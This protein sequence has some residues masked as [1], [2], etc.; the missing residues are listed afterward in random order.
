MSD[1]HLFAL[2]AHKISENVLVKPGKQ[3]VIADEAL[4]H[5]VVHV[6]HLQADEEIVLFDGKVSVQ[7]RL[8]A[9]PKK[10]T[11]TGIVQSRE[12]VIPLQPEITLYQS[13]L[14]REAFGD[15]A[16]Y[17]AQ[18]GVTAFVPVLTHKAHRGWGGEKEKERL[19]SVMISACEQSKQYALP[20]ICDAI[21]FSA[22][23][24]KTWDRASTISIYCD[25]AGKPLLEVL[26]SVASSQG[27]SINVFIGPE[28]G[29]TQTEVDQL[30]QN[31]ATG[32]ALTP[33]ILRS[34][35]AAVLSL[36]AIRS[37][38]R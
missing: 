4:W 6:L 28:G 8:A 22:L 26:Q 19:R 16:Y 17:A 36:G 2:Y 33:S 12:D 20:E 27:K 23:A 24:Q 25:P 18:M 21:E 5:R 7:L 31:G 10:G 13:V 9:A 37:V 32:C 35:D 11:I 1:K 29:F 3:I 15:V 38:A 34:Q 14:K 30:V